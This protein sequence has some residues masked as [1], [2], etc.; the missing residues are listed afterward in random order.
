[1]QCPSTLNYAQSKASFNEAEDLYIKFKRVGTTYTAQYSMDGVNWT[2]RSL[3]TN[4]ASD[5]DVYFIISVETSGTE[6][7][8]TYKNLKIYPI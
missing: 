1:M 4:N 6:R 8:I 2:N 5:N 3:E 7:T